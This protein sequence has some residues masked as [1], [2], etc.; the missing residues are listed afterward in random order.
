MSPAN[1][2]ALSTTQTAG[3]VEKGRMSLSKKA[4]CSYCLISVPGLIQPRK[5]PMDNALSGSRD[6]TPC[7]FGG[8][9]FSALQSIA[10]FTS[11]GN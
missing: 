5:L 2:V 10:V 9:L 8:L 1:R 11:A 7:L 6:P 4:F 3:L